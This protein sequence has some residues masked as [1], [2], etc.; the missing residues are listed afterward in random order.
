MAHKKLL[1]VEGELGVEEAERHAV[2]GGGTVFRDG[3]TVGTGGIALVVVPVV[4]G[5]S[6]VELHHRFVA[7]GLGEHRGGGD[8]GEAAV[9]FYEGGERYVAV[10][11]EP[12]AVDYYGLRTHREQVER[13]VH[14]ENG[15]VEYVDFVDFGRCHYAYAPCHGLAFDDGAQRVA[16]P[17]GE[18]FGVVEE[19]MGEIVGQYYGCGVYVAGQAAASGFVAPGLIDAGHIAYRKWR[20]H[21]CIVNVL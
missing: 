12:V 11:F 1:Q 13:A 16:L 21:Y 19:W 18:L 6:G 2:E 3:L 7:V 15:G 14:G 17:L 4:H 10:G 5:V 8:V 9:A 20:F